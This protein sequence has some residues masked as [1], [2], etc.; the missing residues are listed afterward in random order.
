MSCFAKNIYLKR[1]TFK[2]KARHSPRMDLLFSSLWFSS[3]IFKATNFQAKIWWCFMYTC[4]IIV[5]FLKYLGCIYYLQQR[6]PPIKGFYK[7]RPL[8][9]WVEL[10]DI[11]QAYRWWKPTMNYT[12]KCIRRDAKREWGSGVMVDTTE[13]NPKYNVLCFE[14]DILCR[15]CE[16]QIYI[17][18]AILLFLSY[19]W[20]VVSCRQL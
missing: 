1:E 11:A 16:N 19:L 10:K 8:L 18:I 20:L 13:Q 9:L 17:L 14:Y 3:E 7:I 15:K 5:V 6:V 2:W 12:M 4:Y